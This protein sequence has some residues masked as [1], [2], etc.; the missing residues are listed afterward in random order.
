MAQFRRW[1]DSDEG[2]QPTS[3]RRIGYWSEWNGILCRKTDRR[4]VCGR[5]GLPIPP[6]DRFSFPPWN[7]WTIIAAPVEF[8]W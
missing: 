1:H 6:V 7:S 3:D 2:V 5:I 8:E 4:A